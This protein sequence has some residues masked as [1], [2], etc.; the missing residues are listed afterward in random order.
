MEGGRY[1]IGRCRTFFFYPFFFA[2]PIPELMVRPLALTPN[3]DEARKPPKHKIWLYFLFLSCRCEQS[4]TT[5]KSLSIF[6]V[7]TNFLLLT[8]LT[9]LPTAIL[10]PFLETT[11]PFLHISKRNSPK[12]LAKRL[13]T[14]FGN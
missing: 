10:G 13:T 6:L 14:I 1:K 12:A 4:T 9:T 8:A 7:C 5:S 3:N 11:P 2:N